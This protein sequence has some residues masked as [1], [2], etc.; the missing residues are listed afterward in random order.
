ML[1]AG[2]SGRPLMS[3]ALAFVNE[4]KRSIWAAGVHLGPQ[5]RTLE[6]GSGWGAT[7]RALMRDLDLKKFVGAEPEPSFLSVAQE[8]FPSGTFHF[9]PN[10][11][12]YQFNDEEFDLIYLH[13]IFTH[14][15]ENTFQ[16][17]LDEIYRIAK[18]GAFVAFTV[19]PIEAFESVTGI[20]SAELRRK[21]DVG[22]YIYLPTGG[23]TAVMP[24]E[25][26]G[27]AV[28][29]RK[30]LERALTPRSFKLL[31][32]GGIQNHSQT[33]VLVR[34]TLAAGP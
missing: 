18:P 4:L 31:H 15:S 34:R 28:V 22:E 10:Q 13:S 16:S 25:I 2:Q 23:G 26:Y 19:L 5:T 3:S 32:M 1:L 12:P 9:I 7:Y 11:P 17:V 24:P 20:A 21:V 6:I 14:L 30:Y 8:T 27:W 29:S 33:F